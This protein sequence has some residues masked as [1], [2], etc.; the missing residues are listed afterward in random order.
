MRTQAPYPHRIISLEPSI[1]ATVLAL[2]GRERLIAVSEH[3][4]RLVGE[5]AIKGLP[6]VPCTWS[7]TAEDVLP[8]APDLVIASVPM[9]RESV[10]ALLRAGL[11]VLALYPQR[12]E[13]V[14]NNIRLL[15]ALLDARERG[16]E[17]IADMELRF[18]RLWE[19][20]SQKSPVRV[21]MEVWPRPLMNGPAWHADLLSIV[22]GEFVP[23]GPN[24]RL[25]E[26]EVIEADPEVIVVVW[27]G[28]DD[29][30]LRRVY[31]RPGWEEVS[32]IREKRVVTVPEI[33]VNAPGVN[34]ARGAE[35]LAEAIWR[36]I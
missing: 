2:G 18:A 14:Y 33:W 5:E 15:A 31:E 3:D 30:P 16:D 23:P 32:A 28:V 29:P 35:W 19:A 9:R 10:E 7:V 24:R 17:L 8:L 26:N 1:T 4:E 27:P 6:R 22:G 11:N 34:L 12:L 21:F 36:F 20:S 13:D 25:D